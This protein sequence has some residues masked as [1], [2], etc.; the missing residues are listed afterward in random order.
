M[1]IT[2]TLNKKIIYAILKIFKYLKITL[3]N[4]KKGYSSVILF[5]SLCINNSKL[6]PLFVFTIVIIMPKKTQI[7]KKSRKN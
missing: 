1:K 5:I 4:L 3:Y 6:I 7:N 2:I